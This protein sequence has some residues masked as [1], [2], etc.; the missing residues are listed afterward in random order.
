[1]A[2]HKRNIIRYIL[3]YVLGPTFFVILIPAGIY[4]LSSISF[5]VF[6]TPIIPDY[7]ARITV[8]SILLIVGAGYIL[9]SNIYL[10]LI[11]KGGPTDILVVAVT[12]RTKKLVATGPYRNTRNPMV[13][14]AFSLYF[15]IAIYFDSL[16]C[17]LVL[18]LLFFLV[19]KFILPAEEK[20]LLKD[21]GDDFLKYKE[22]TSVIIPLPRKKPPREN[23]G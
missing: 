11:G 10:L 14:G 2:D 5:S 16:G 3:G 17:L 12:P 9:W 20:R 6:Q 4:Y 21:F 1:M 22:R 13:F 8:S 23:S 18:A 15:S 7:L 19:I